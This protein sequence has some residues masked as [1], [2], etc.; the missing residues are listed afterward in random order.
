MFNKNQIRKKIKIILFDDFNA[1]FQNWRYRDKN[2]A[3]EA[4]EH[5]CTQKALSLCFIIEVTDFS[6]L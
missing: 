2:Q 4:I 5:F 1:H 3:G 6:T